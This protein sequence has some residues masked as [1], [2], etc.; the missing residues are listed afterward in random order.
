MIKIVV[1]SIV[2]ISIFIAL[3]DVIDLYKSYDF[4]KPNFVLVSLQVV[5]GLLII[6]V[7]VN[8]LWFIFTS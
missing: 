4:S 6:S 2:F 7:V 5:I 3:Y 1:L 8:L